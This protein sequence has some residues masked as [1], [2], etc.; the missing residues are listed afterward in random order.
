MN[1]KNQVLIAQAVNFFQGGLVDDA[2]TILLKVLKAQSN[3]LPAL[4]ILGLIKATQGSP[5]ESATYLKRAVQINPSNPSTQYNLAK[6]LSEMGDDITAIVHHE[7]A[8]KLSP[9]NADGWINYGKSLAATNNHAR[10]IFAFEK[11]ILLN[12]KSI[13]A[14]L[15]KG[16]ALLAMGAAE[17]SLSDF[18]VVLEFD[19]NNLSALARKGKALLELKRFNES[20][21]CLEQALKIKPFDFDTLLIVG[22]NLYSQKRFEDALAVSESALSIDP[23]S[24]DVLSNIGAILNGQNRYSE[25]IPFFLN[26]ITRN[27]QSATA[28]ANLG[29]AYDE[30]NQY[31]DALAGYNEALKIDPSLEFLLGSRLR[32]KQILGVWSGFDIDAKEIVRL[33]KAGKESITPFGVLSIVD[34]PE[35]HYLCAKKWASKFTHLKPFSSNIK[36]IDQGKARIKIAYFSADFKS[37][38]VGYITS[39]LFQLHDRTQFEI[40]AFSLSDAGLGDAVRNQLKGSFDHFID[41]DKKTDAEIATLAREIGIDIAIDLGGYTA[42]ARV[43]IF[44]YRAAPI[45]VNFLGYPGTLGSDSY[46]YI[47]ADQVVIP[48]E[49]Y[50]FYTEKIASLPGSYMP[51]DSRRLPAPRSFTRA[52][53]GLADDKVI[54]CCFNNSYKFNE[55]VAECWASI[56]LNVD[57][58]LLWISANNSEF[59]ANILAAFNTFS[60]PSDRIVFAERIHSMDEHLSRIMLA[61]IFLDTW[62]FN[63][64]STA[65][66]TLKVGVPIITFIGKSFPARVAASLLYAVGMP[67]LVTQTKSDYQRLAIDLGGN[68]KKLAQVKQDL[69]NK[70][71]SLALFNTPLFAKKLEAAYLQ[72][73]GRL[74]ANLPPDHFQIS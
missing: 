6:V 46:D 24:A 36:S 22:L 63:A 53:F 69:K 74:E 26:A 10:A 70:V 7:K 8:L 13:D 33:I 65:L 66:D 67:D 2:E 14:H 19:N 51:D 71:S 18:D 4:E 54:F 52:D 9:N 35:I 48:A 42:S 73:H 38:P 59:R 61:D 68:S 17:E 20:L 27:N 60:I 1:N 49:S 15:N 5:K 32:I 31:Q 56:L 30:L 50:Q 57:N 23:N 64:H 3:S 41:V 44:K 25:A 62:P 16:I 47:I 39:E 58:S 21:E 11:A 43:E 29:L 37:H 34:S 12:P 55:E 45:Q 28:Y 40:Y 72:M